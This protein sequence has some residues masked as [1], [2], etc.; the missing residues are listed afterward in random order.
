MRLSESLELIK[1]QVAELGTVLAK[2]RT[3]AWMTVPQVGKL[4]SAIATD[5]EAALDG[6]ETY[7]ETHRSTKT[8]EHRITEKMTAY[9][10]HGERVNVIAF[11]IVGGSDFD[12]RGEVNPTSRDQQRDS[13]QVQ[14]DIGADE[15]SADYEQLDGRNDDE[16]R[17][18][19]E[20]VELDRNLHEETNVDEHEH[21]PAS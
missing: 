1:D 13:G 14:T 17:Y 3:D 7:A 20:E 2:E 5:L 15:E 6:D 10:W 11:T 12:G 19:E 8:L 18:T 9:E 21:H 4:I 16:K